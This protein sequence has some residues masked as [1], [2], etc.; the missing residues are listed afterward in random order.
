MQT[1]ASL[2]RPPC[3]GT[4]GRSWAPSAGCDLASHHLGPRSPSCLH[5]AIAICTSLWHQDLSALHSVRPTSA[6]LGSASP[7]KAGMRSS[8]ETPHNT[9]PPTIMYLIDS[10]GCCQFNVLLYPKPFQA[11]LRASRTVAFR[12]R[13]WFKD[14]NHF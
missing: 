4:G 8:L 6:P 7:S 3:R 14:G 13:C 2:V 11:K 9:S 10:S 1:Q 12:R 5:T